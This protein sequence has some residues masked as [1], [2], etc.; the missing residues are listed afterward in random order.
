[1]AW[2][3]PFSALP[4]LDW[5]QVEISSF[6]NAACCYCPRTLFRER[7]QDRLFELDRFRR[8]LPVCKKT[9]LVFL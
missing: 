6:C 3:W 9:K 8:L 5:L 7:W 4:R 1:M 2:Y